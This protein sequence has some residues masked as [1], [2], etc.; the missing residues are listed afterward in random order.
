M[1]GWNNNDGDI[2]A[3]DDI[4][5]YDYQNGSPE[6][7]PDLTHSQPASEPL[8][9]FNSSNG[10]S[11]RSDPEHQYLSPMNESFYDQRHYGVSTDRAGPPATWGYDDN[12]D[13]FGA[14]GSQFQPSSGSPNYSTSSS[15]GHFHAPHDHVFAGTYSFPDV[16]PPGQYEYPVASQYFQ[17]PNPVNHARLSLPEPIND[18]YEPMISCKTQGGQGARRAGRSARSSSIERMRQC[19]RSGP[20]VCLQQGCTSKPFN[21]PADLERHYIQLHGSDQ[22]KKSFYCDYNRCNRATS[23]FHRLDHCREHFREFHKEDIDKR[24]VPLTLE[25]CQDRNIKTNW[26]RCNKCLARVTVHDDGFRC[27]HCHYEC[28]EVRRRI[29]GA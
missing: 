29:R 9:R 20:L 18:F 4:A 8:S 23:P 10:N 28:P 19:K 13:G 24:G 5:Y 22:E 25:W 15:F 14:L 16:P 26:W 3:F 27:P 7:V 1:T 21:R 17:S 12:T 2:F 11:N 6:D